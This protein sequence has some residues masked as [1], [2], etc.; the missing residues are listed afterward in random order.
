MFKK[1]IIAIFAAMFLF[2]TS[3]TSAQ[4]ADDDDDE[5]YYE[6]IDDDDDDDSDYYD[7]DDDDSEEIED[8]FDD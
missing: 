6:D 5:Y 3:Y 7:D 4:Y 8:L 1:S 2:G